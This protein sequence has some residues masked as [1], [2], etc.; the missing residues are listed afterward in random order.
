MALCLAATQ[1][2]VLNDALPGFG[3]DYDG[4]LALDGRW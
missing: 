4:T 3:C 1:E 2:G